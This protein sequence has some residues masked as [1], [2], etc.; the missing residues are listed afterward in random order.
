MIDQTAGNLGRLQPHYVHPSWIDLTALLYLM[1][2]YRPSPGYP[3]MDRDR[4]AILRKEATRCVTLYRELIDAQRAAFNLLYLLQVYTACT[5]LLYSLVEMDGEPSNMASREWR[6]ETVRLVGVCLDLLDA[7]Q[8]GWPGTEAYRQQF[9]AQSVKL[10]EKCEAASAQEEA[11][12]QNETGFPGLDS[13]LESV[14]PWPNT[15]EFDWS[16]FDIAGFP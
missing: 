9:I 7:F 15:S 10:V 2:L 14:P 4:F 16:L 6:E 11:Q 12:A 1:A 3:Y 8:A 13:F 5:T